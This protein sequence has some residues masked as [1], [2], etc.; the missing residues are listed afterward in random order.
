MHEIDTYNYLGVLQPRQI[1]HITIKKQLTTVQTSRLQAILKTDLKSKN[2]TKAIN[3][4]VIPSSTYLF[5]LHHGLRQILSF[6]VQ[7]Y[8]SI[9]HRY[10]TL[11]KGGRI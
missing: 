11:K 5:A 6:E 4:C 10:P 1:Q 2:L 3:V 8:T 7:T 9:A